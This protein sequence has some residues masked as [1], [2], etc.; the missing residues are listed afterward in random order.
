MQFSLCSRMQLSLSL[1]EGAVPLTIPTPDCLRWHSGR[2]CS[3]VACLNHPAKLGRLAQLLFCVCE[4]LTL[5]KS[6]YYRL[7]H[8]SELS[9]PI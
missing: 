1:F 2:T 5:E 4:T 9:Q 6:P 7:P 3:L 8:G